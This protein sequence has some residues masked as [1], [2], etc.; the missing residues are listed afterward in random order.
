[1]QIKHSLIYSIGASEYDATIGDF[2]FINMLELLN[3]K[4]ILPYQ[5]LAV[6]MGG[7]NDQA[8]GMF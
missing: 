1:M 5:L 6:S 8:V 2:N 7:N 4:N 3:Q